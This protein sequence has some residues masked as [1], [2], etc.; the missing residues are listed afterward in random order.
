MDRMSNWCE[1]VFV[2]AVF[3]IQGFWEGHGK[4]SPKILIYGKRY[5]L[6][7]FILIEQ[8]DR[9]LIALTQKSLTVWS[10]K[11]NHRKAD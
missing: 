4:I 10:R 5:G 6:S 3:R 1:A 8:L 9:F 2:N 11:M 7:R